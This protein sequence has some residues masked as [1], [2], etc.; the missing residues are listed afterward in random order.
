MEQF[1]LYFFVL[2]YSEMRSHNLSHLYGNE[3]LVHSL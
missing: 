3:I 2:Y 1:F